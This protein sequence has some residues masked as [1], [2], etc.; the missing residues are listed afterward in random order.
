MEVPVCSV[1]IPAHNCLQY[2]PTALSSAAAQRGVEFEV[3]VVDD[4][5][6]DGTDAWL[7]ERCRQWPAL[8]ALETGGIGPGKARN[9]G[10]EAAR[11]PLIAFLDA[12]DWWWPDKLAAQVTY[13]AAHPETAF[14]FTDYLHV[15]ADG[16]SRGSCFEYWKPRLA[17]R[18]V[19]GYFRLNDA[20]SI[21]LATNLVG[22]TTVLASKAALERAGGFELLPSAEDWALWLR[23]ASDAP[24]ACTRAI[25]ASYLMRSSSLTANREAR[26]AAMA[27]I[28]A[29]YEKSTSPGV[30]QAAAKARARIDVARAELARLS[31]RH[32]SAAIYHSRAFLAL[33]SARLGKETTASILN[34]ALHFVSGY[35]ASK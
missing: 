25:T 13:H 14:S 27:E 35:G 1:V 12:D 23:L 16:E 30:R 31:G 26:I 21:I 15:S 5:S 20:L 18:P 3:I 33:P 34:A 17:R 6:T 2:L 9:A 29:P 19:S 24:V 28:I 22:T 11:A 7:E 32:S 8:R 10:I 4:G